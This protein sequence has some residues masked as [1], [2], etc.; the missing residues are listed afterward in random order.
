MNELQYTFLSDGASDRALMPVL[1]WLLHQH[2]PNCAIQS[3]WPDLRRLPRPPR[4]LHERIRAAVDLSRCDLLFIHRDA[5]TLSLR[6][7]Q[8]QVD[9]A[10]SLA[11]QA[12]RLPPAI[13]V[14]P[15]RMTEAWLLFDVPAI[16]AAAGNPNGSVDLELPRLADLE[17]IPDPKGVL[18]RAILAA[19]EVGAHRRSRFNASS[20]IHRIAQYIEDF[21]PLRVLSAFAAL[22][23]RIQE[24]IRKH[25]WR[26]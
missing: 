4:E 18:R 1:T 12:V 15:V 24:A 3:H 6:D 19:T 7:R 8:T 26:Q 14:I 11:R 20:A 13:A 10:V 25:G 17:D 16:R 21:A 23:N 5:K 22:E 9:E 2:V